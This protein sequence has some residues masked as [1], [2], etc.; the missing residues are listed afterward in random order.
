MN[1]RISITPDVCHGKPVIKGTRVLV[2]NV[3]GSL[4]AGETRAEIMENYPGLTEDD[5]RAAL[6]FGSE[7]ARFEVIGQ[8]A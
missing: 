6:E 2:S 3:L 5:I 7:L 4:A 8:T 1:P